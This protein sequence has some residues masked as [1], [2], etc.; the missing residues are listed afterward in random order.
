MAINRLARKGNNRE[1]KLSFAGHVVM[2]NR[3]GL[4]VD[5]D[6]TEAN[7]YAEREAGLRMLERIRKGVR[8]RTIA[9]DKGSP[10][11]TIPAKPTTTAATPAT[12]QRVDA[13]VMP[14]LSHRHPISIPGGSCG[15]ARTPLA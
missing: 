15:F 5:V 13:L 3:S 8:R 6:L 11:T 1:A 2:E 10:M 4:V 14:L 7:G 9:G 12:S